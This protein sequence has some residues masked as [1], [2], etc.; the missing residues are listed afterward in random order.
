MILNIIGFFICHK[1]GGIFAQSEKGLC[2]YDLSLESRR[3]IP[4]AFYEERRSTGGNIPAFMEY[5]ELE[6]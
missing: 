5:L 6:R 1:Y 2:Y 3:K 4:V